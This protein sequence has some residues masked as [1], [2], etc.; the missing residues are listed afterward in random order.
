MTVFF[1]LYHLC[2]VMFCI[3]LLVGV[4]YLGVAAVALLCSAPFMAL[5][6]MSMTSC[7]VHTCFPS[8]FFVAWN[9]C[10]H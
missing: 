6:C 4:D 3:G 1:C 7:H 2:K 8:Q 5:N 10:N 9:M